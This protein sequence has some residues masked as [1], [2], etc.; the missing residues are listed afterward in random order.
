[1]EGEQGADRGGGFAGGAEEDRGCR[2]RSERF[3]DFYEA[4]AGGERKGNLAPS[5]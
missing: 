4:R 5:K 3:F 1:V 2:L